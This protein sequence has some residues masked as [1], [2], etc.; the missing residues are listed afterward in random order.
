MP[1]QVPVIDPFSRETQPSA[2]HGVPLGGIGACSIGRGFR[3]EFNR[4]QF[5]AGQCEDAPVDADQFSVFITRQAES[6]VDEPRK[7]SSVLYPGVPKGVRRKASGLGIDAW[8]WNMD[9]SR[10]TYYALFPRAWTVYQ[11]PD[12]QMT[13]SCRQVSPFIPNNYQESSLPSSV[14]AFTLAN[15]GTT[16]ADV[17]L[18]FSLANSVGGDSATTGGHLNTAFE[19]DRGIKGVKLQHRSSKVGGPV[20]LAIAARGGSGTRESHSP[21]AS[22]PTHSPVT[23]H[24]TNGTADSAEGTADS[25]TDGVR[26][27]VCP[28][29]VLSGPCKGLSAADMWQHL[30]K[31]GT[32]PPHH[33]SALASH[34]SFPGTAIGAAV[35]AS[36]SVPP[37]AT[38]HVDFTLCWDVPVA[39]F[40]PDSHYLRCPLLGDGT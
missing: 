34:P 36:V 3:G 6:S 17:S 4:W 28:H 14:F 38:R 13:I 20:T 23:A 18:V 12:P 19:M 21:A 7:F 8:G 1:L 16:A 37:G 15:T 2:C 9:G 5:A 32:L 35:A 40:N 25:S 26:V 10:N 39:R 30:E 29:F 31:T 11:E 33:E 27:S 22:A 24:S